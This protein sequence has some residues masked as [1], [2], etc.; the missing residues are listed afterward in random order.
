MYIPHITIMDKKCFECILFDDGYEC[1]HDKDEIGI[2][3]T[4]NHFKRYDGSTN[5]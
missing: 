4:C 2:I 1:E 3:Y 5:R